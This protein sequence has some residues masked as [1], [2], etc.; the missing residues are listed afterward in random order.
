MKHPHDAGQSC[1]G[2]RLRCFLG[3]ARLLSLDLDLHLD[4]T[5]ASWPFEQ[6]AVS[7]VFRLLWGQG[8]I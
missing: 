2:G 3:V 6:D 5:L 1:E 4:I 8:N 7:R